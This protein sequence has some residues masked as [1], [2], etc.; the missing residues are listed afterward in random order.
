MSDK[1]S[2]STLIDQFTKDSGKDPKFIEELRKH[3]GDA[4]HEGL[5]KD[6]TV[7]LNGLGTFYLKRSEVRQG[8]NPQTGDKIEIPAH[9][10][11][12]FRPDASVRRIINKEYDHLKAFILD[13]ND[14]KQKSKVP[15]WVL[16]LIAILLISVIGLVLNPKEVVEEVIVEKEI[17][18]VEEVVVVKEVPVIEEVVVIKEVPVIETVVVIKEVPVP[19]EAPAAESAPLAQADASDIREDIAQM[20]TADGTLD[21]PS[22]SGGYIDPDIAAAEAGMAEAEADEAVVKAEEAIAE[23]KIAE[24]EAQNTPD[25]SFAEEDAAE[26]EVSAEKAEAEAQEAIYEAMKADDKAE[27]AAEA[28]RM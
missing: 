13:E 1:I 26:A 18:I 3:M 19:M 27:A 15:V 28:E 9:N 6:G 2:Y 22:G 23:A 7:H 12:N 25:S 4:L 21:D 5:E 14:E 8:T 17:T 24:I 11:V 10:R 20:P 16:A